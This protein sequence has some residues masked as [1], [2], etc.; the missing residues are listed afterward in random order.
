MLMVKP[1]L[2]YLDVVR[3]VKDKVSSDWGG[4]ASSLWWCLSGGAFGHSPSQKQLPLSRSPHLPPLPRYCLVSSA[5]AHR[6]LWAA[7]AGQFLNELGYLS[8]GGGESEWGRE[9]GTVT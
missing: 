7:L 8:V 3:E 9:E 1:G 2:P 4:R 5:S 6:T